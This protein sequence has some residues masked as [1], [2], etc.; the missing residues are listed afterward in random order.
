M[1]TKGAD[2]T[3]AESRENSPD[4]H[5]DSTE[6]RTSKK[7]KVLSCF[8]CRSRKMKCDRVYP[9]CG[10]CQKTGRRDQ[11]TYDPRLLEES[12]VNG[13][14]HA[15]GG[16]SSFAVPE[17]NTHDTAHSSPDELRWKLRVQERRIEMLEQKLAAKD[18]AKDP[19]QYED[20]APEEPELKEA[21]IFRGKGFKTQFQGATSVMSVIA[22][23]R[24]LQAFTR[25]TMK[26]DHSITRVKT[27]F[28]TFR[29]RRKA[30]SK[31]KDASVFCVEEEVISALPERS[32]VDGQVALYFQTWETTYRILHEPSFWKEYYE[33]WELRSSDGA[34]IS[35]TI[36]LVLIVT[37]TKCLTAKD[38]VF[39]GDSTA[40]RQAASELIEVCETWINRQPR[41]RLTLEFFQI[42]CLSLL[43][44]RVNCVKL[45]QDWVT[46]GDLVR[47][48]LA[49][50]MHRNP[51]LLAS[52]R[53]SEF[54]KEMKK[55][56]WVTIM[57]FEIQ[58]SLE[59]GLQSSLTG[60]YFDAPAPGNLSDDAFSIDVSEMPTS[61]SIEHFTSASYLNV[62][63]RSLPLRIH[64]AQLLN[65][66]SSDLQY[67]DV[68][69]YDAQVNSLLTSIPSWNDERAT[70]PAALLRLQLSQYLLI[71]H[72][73]YAKLAAGNKHYMYS[74]TASIDVVSSMIATHDELIGKGIL[75]LNNFRNDVVRVGLTLS[76]IV[77]H[78]CTK[79]GPIKSSAAPTSNIESHFAGLQT[80]FGDLPSV[81]SWIP[82]DTG[83]MLT[84]IPQQPLLAKVLCTSAVEILERSRQIFEQKV[85]RLG[86]GWME[87]WL[88]CAAVGML[89]SA[90]SPA[91]SIA[92][93]TN[94]SDDVLSRCRVALDR[95]TT[96]TFR[97]LALQKDPGNS[98]AIS[99]RDT[100][101]SVSPSDVR[102]PSTS[103]VV[104]GARSGLGATPSVTGYAN[105][106]VIPDTNMGMGIADGSKDMTGPFDALQDM[107]VDMGGWSFPDF[108]AF[109]LGGDF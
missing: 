67:S 50:G 84:I 63:L 22:Q 14:V 95:F 86:T 90:P 52:G 23:Y 74:L 13:R 16:S 20:R 68:L 30:A 33:F 101:A 62:T 34:S 28:K 70:I 11:C 102:T 41:K 61:M 32:V 26:V 5:E 39:L 109:D 8:A 106:P 40:D 51:S 64:L 43:A 55:R 71:L 78:N 82:P 104:V 27:D 19:S 58:S 73:P 4:G 48:A 92:Y 100:M 21:M 49:S 1:S 81:K 79:S 80:H 59:H 85:L 91:T 105:V 72:K 35:F 75:A 42:H 44:K 57:E 37:I 31:Q 2:G 107:Q 108:W 93:V 53:I 83:L 99:L 103:A 60:L 98:F 96:L 9:V 77:Y 10:R 76:Q 69:H 87:F 7:R 29:S 18:S 45:K 3:E 24:E 94:T 25:E 47:L 46:S 6:K 89:P 97:V 54:E 56:L 65:N 36:I 12:H 17:N 38:D 66:P 15:D 88:L